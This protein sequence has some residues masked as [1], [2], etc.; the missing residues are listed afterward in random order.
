[1]IEL[2]SHV[3]ALQSQV[4]ALLVGQVPVLRALERIEA[5]LEEPKTYPAAVGGTITVS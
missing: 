4:K 2:E 1:M 5:L 3:V